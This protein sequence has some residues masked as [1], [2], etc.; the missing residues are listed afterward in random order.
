MVSVA[1]GKSLFHRAKLARWRFWAQ[2]GFLL[3]WLDPLLVR[4]HSVCG[5]VFH[6]YSCPL[7]TFACPIGVLAQFSALHVLPLIAIGTLVAVGAVV[8]SFVCGWAC[9]FGFL[10]D[11]LARIPT[12]KFSLPAWTGVFRY[13]VLIALVL[14]IPYWYGEEHELFFCRVC[15]AGTLEGAIPNT[16]QLVLS[17]QANVHP[18]PTQQEPAASDPAGQDA[19]QQDAAGQAVPWPSRTRIVILVAVLAAALVAWR[20]WCTLLCPLGAIYA[21]CNRFSMVF[22][23]FHSDRCRDCKVC[24]SLC[25]GGD[26]PNRRVDGL[27]CVRCMECQQCQAVSI[28][29]VF[30]PGEKGPGGPGPELVTLDRPRF[31]SG[32]GGCG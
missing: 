32:S 7:A 28:G 22:M 4:M 20:P 25:R 12:P 1:K 16:V 23:R 15:P 19:T 27:R 17:R 6:C 5:P 24:R 13:V 2:L 8:G 31:P 14:A 21:V 3:A 30:S 9:P 18:D 29:T 26:R 11:L 10:Q